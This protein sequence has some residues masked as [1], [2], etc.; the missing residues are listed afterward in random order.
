MIECTVGMIE[1]IGTCEF[2]GRSVLAEPFHV[3][4]GIV[5]RPVLGFFFCARRWFG[6]MGGKYSAEPS[7]GLMLSAGDL[8]GESGIFSFF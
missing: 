8:I 2:N 4:V 7:R 1:L 3:R 6:V 5:G